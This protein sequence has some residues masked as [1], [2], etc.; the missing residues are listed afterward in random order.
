MIRPEILKRITFAKFL[1]IQGHESLQSSS[2]IADGVSVSLYQDAAEMLLR[3]VAENFDADIKPKTS[4]DELSHAIEIANKNINKIKISSKIAISQLN[5]SR[6][7]FKHHGL[8]PTH[9][10]AKK[11]S[12]DIEV[13]FQRTVE[14]CFG[15]NYEDISLADVVKN[16]RIRNFLKLAEKCFYNTQLSES[17]LNSAKAFILILKNT[18]FTEIGERF[19]RFRNFDNRNL[20][21]ALMDIKESITEHERQ[22][23][24]LKYGINLT[25][26]MHFRNITPTL[27]LTAAG[28]FHT[29]YLRDIND[30]ELENIARFC[31][32]FVVLSAI[33]VQQ[34]KHIEP[35]RYKEKFDRN[36]VVI[37]PAEIIVYPIDCQDQNQ[38]E[39]IK[40]ASKGDILIGN[41][42]RYDKGDY[43]A[44]I[45]DD[46]LAY[47]SKVS[48][49]AI[50]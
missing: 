50:G 39:V 35:K 11:F 28:T 49:K 20:S 19:Y 2:P 41:Y 15:L 9:D 42:P 24:I 12:H 21:E 31:L 17:I 8:L 45:H 33:N 44:V 46:D 30:N 13:F 7:N 40:I 29:E 36:F 16:D 43:I 18:S 37:E 10:D 22:L 47:I 3:S 34:N 25:D 6:V 27:S 1:L 26:Y 4:F 38:L 5:K 14:D 23:N 48:V 32:G